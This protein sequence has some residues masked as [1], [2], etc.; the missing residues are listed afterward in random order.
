MPKIPHRKL[1]RN[2]QNAWEAALDQTDSGADERAQLGEIEPGAEDRGGGDKG[3]DND[4]GDGGYGGDAALAGADEAF[5]EPDRPL[6]AE[7][8]GDPRTHAGQSYPGVTKVSDR[9]QRE[10]GREDVEDDET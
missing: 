3:F 9:G 8:T 4:T 5:D 6:D 7:I 10:I 2:P 1:L